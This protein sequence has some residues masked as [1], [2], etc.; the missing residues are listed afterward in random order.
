MIEGEVDV[1]EEERDGEE[2]VKELAWGVIL[3]HLHPNLLLLAV[4]T[5]NEVVRV[6]EVHVIR[7]HA[8]KFISSLAFDI[9]NKVSD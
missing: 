9:L 1:L 6:A 4:S 2:T 8:A 3:K 5:L 7:P